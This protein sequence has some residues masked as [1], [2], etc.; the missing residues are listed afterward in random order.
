[1]KFERRNSFSITNPSL[2]KESSSASNSTSQCL[3]R[4]VALSRP[5]RERGL[6]RLFHRSTPG[7]PSVRDAT[8]AA[9]SAQGWPKFPPRQSIL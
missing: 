9:M 3:A 8:I 6:A 2:G 7:S 5:T 4:L 1:M